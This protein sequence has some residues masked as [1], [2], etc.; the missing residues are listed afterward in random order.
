VH[1]TAPAAVG[2][3]INEVR[4]VTMTDV[5]EHV[6]DDRSLL[7]DVVQACPS[8][9]WFILTVPADMSLWSDHDVVLGHYRRYDASG[10]CALWRD[11]PVSCE[12]LAPLNRRLEPV[13]R[14]VRGFRRFW[15]GGRGA[16]GTDLS[17]PAPP[18]NRLLHHVFAAESD[19]ILRSLA[20]RRLVAAGRGVSLLAI[21]RRH[22]HRSPM[23]GCS[24]SGAPGSPLEILVD[25]RLSSD[26][27]DRQR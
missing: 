24:G 22:P 23:G 7:A 26:V 25:P 14:L 1:G 8:G 6:R 11:L 21:L 16:A 4:L 20:E 15:G 19:G 27:R 10:F 12:L 13:V 17:L 9:T 2:P 3:R 18:L 5:L